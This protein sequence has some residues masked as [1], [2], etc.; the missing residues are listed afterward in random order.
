MT[1]R[2]VLMRRRRLHRRGRASGSSWCT[3]GG[4]SDRMGSS[5]TAPRGY[6]ERRTRTTMTTTMTTTTTT[7]KQKLKKQKKKQKQK[8]MTLMVKRAKGVVLVVV[9][10][11]V[12]VVVSVGRCGHDG[13]GG[14]S[15][16]YSSWWE[17]P[18]GWPCCRRRASTCVS[19]APSPSAP[20]GDRPQLREAVAGALGDGVGRGEPA[21]RACPR[22]AVQSGAWSSRS[23]W[24]QWLWLWLWQRQLRQRQWR[25]R[26]Q[27]Q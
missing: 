23:A 21:P 1:T 24:W 25:Q 19:V 11:V 5:S 12:V 15:A 2:A 9:V 3:T 17:T 14:G 26:Q 20:A 27:Q 13:G 22:A 7:T 4:V 18:C 8:Q 16:R 6:S 10:V